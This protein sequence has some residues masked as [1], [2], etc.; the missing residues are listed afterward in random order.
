MTGRSRVWLGVRGV[1]RNPVGRWFDEGV[2]VGG[3]GSGRRLELS[4]GGRRRGEEETEVRRVDPL[5]VR[6]GL[7]LW[8]LRNGYQSHSESTSDGSGRSLDETLCDRRTTVSSSTLAQSLPRSVSVVVEAAPPEGSSRQH[9]LDFLF[10]KGPCVRDRRH[11]SLLG[12]TVHTRHTCRSEGLPLSS[13]SS[14]RF[15]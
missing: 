1:V 13:P 10:R 14:R 8:G 12:Q 9:T 11:R 2:G 7:I 15:S 5:R 3:S 4:R 6:G